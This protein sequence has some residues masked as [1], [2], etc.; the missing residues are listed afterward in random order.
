MASSKT[1][2]I[3]IIPGPPEIGLLSTFLCLP[4]PYFFKSIVSRDQSLFSN[5]LPVTEADNGP[6][7]SSGKRVITLAL[8]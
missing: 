7:K 5:A 2:G 4:F 8:N 1:S 6:G 3:K